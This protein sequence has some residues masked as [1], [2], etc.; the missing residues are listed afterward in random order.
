[1]VFLGVVKVQLLT[2]HSFCFLFAHSAS[3]PTRLAPL[4]VA[5]NSKPLLP[6]QERSITGGSVSFASL[7]ARLAVALLPL[8]LNRRAAS[9]TWDGRCTKQLRG[10]LQARSTRSVTV[11]LPGLSIRVVQ[12]WSKPRGLLL[13]QLS[14][15]ITAA[16]GS[17]RRLGG[18]L[19]ATMPGG[20]VA[21]AG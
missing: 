13:N 14:V 18:K 5:T 12:P 19:G 8:G 10:L 7:K 3:Q 4:A 6:S 2:M 21:A 15:T 20:G 1:V 9:L 16:A 11:K 17:K